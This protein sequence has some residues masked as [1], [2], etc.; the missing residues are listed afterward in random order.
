VAEHLT[1]PR[2]VALPVW[3][4]LRSRGAAP[5]A[6]GPDT[7]RATVSNA[8]FAL[9]TAGGRL[10]GA[11]MLAASALDA[12]ADTA[13]LAAVRR[14]DSAGVFAGPPLKA[15]QKLAVYVG[16]G[17][18]DRDL[19]VQTARGQDAAAFATAAGTVAVPVA[20]VRRD[21][22]VAGA[23][24]GVARSPDRA[25]SDSVLRTAPTTNSTALVDY[26]V[27]TAGAVAPGT[28]LMTRFSRPAYGRATADV[29]ARY[30]FTPARV[31]GCAVPTLE[32]WSSTL[33]VNY[34]PEWLVV[35]D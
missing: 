5:R 29:V 27:D 12:R 26:A 34:G 17:T 11:P 20:L 3:L 31:A 28:V 2:P 22:L 9:V 16:L 4:S 23:R 13:V 14:A 33:R 30:Q 6:T 35:P 24:L 1:L 8:V 7:L 21:L 18:R 32:R 25:F 10:E 15:G 19:D